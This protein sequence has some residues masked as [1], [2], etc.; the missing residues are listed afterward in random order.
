MIA[1]NYLQKNE[2]N[3][4]WQRVGDGLSSADDTA[5]GFSLATETW[6]KK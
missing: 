4:P 3:L 6:K 2:F 1:I 5:G